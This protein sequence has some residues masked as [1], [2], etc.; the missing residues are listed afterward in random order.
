[1]TYSIGIT[2]FKRREKLLVKLVRSIRNYTD[3]PILISN[4]ADNKE[5]HDPTYIRRM[6]AFCASFDN[7]LPTVFPA[8]TSLAK[9]WNTLIVNCATS[10]ILV[11]NDDILLQADIFPGIPPK[12]DLLLLNGSWSHF[13]ISKRMAQ[14]LN[15]FDERLLAFGEEDG[16][17]TWKYEHL[18]GQKPAVLTVQGLINIGEGYRHSSSKLNLIDVNGRVYRPAFNRQFLFGKMYRKGGT[19]SSMFGEPHERIIK[20]YIQYPYEAFK[21]ENYDQL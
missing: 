4:N 9:M 16:D 8:F 11:L 5:P 2:T 18:Y 14:K 1:M 13:I 12:A 21:E 20:D 17:M 19:V 10:S 3:L 6:L 15:F 7:V